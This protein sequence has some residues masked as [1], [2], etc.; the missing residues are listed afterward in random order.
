MKHACLEG[1]FICNSRIMLLPFLLRG[2]TAKHYVQQALSSTRLCVNYCNIRG[3]ATSSGQL[4]L[5]RT[6]QRFLNQS[7]GAK[8]HKRKHQNQE[9]DWKKR[10][11]TVLTYI[12]AAG[13]G[14]IGL[15][16][17]AVP[18]YRLYCQVSITLIISIKVFFLWIYGITITCSFSF[19]RQQGW[20]AQQ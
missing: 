14:M 13:V 2:C 4:F 12:A 9:D 17:A 11:K 1:H 18:L 3:L 10:N 6:P 7:R 8:T 19:I 16:Y 20:E 15:S 5:R